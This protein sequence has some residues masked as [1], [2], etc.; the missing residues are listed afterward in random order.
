MGFCCPPN[1]VRTIPKVSGWAYSLAENGI[2]VNL[3]GGNK[4]ATKMLDGSEIIL[5]QET[6]YPWEGQVKI[7][8]QKCKKEPFKVLLRIPEWRWYIYQ[9]EWNR[10][11]C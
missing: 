3:Y 2:A 4:L 1:V 11:R 9:G 6:Q 7:T 5:I 8:L 10:H